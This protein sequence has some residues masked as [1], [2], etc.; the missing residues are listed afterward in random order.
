MEDD[1]EEGVDGGEDDG[2]VDGGFLPSPWP[3]H[4]EEHSPLGG[5]ELSPCILKFLSS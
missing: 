2:G 4:P 1:E 3:P 5:L